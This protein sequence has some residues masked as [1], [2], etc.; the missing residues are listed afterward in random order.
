MQPSGH[1]RYKL[2]LFNTVSIFLPWK[3]YQIRLALSTPIDDIVVTLNVS[4]VQFGESNS[5]RRACVLLFCACGVQEEGMA[6]AGMDDGHGG[7]QDRLEINSYDQ[8]S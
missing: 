4:E 5:S 8:A 1:G 3:R 7:H 2:F 6:G